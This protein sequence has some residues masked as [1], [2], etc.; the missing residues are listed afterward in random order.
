[1]EGATFNDL[2]QDIR[3]GLIDR[4]V[5][6]I[7]LNDKSDLQVRFD[8]FERL[9]TGGVELTDHEIRESV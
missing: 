8:L 4:P 1:M 6:V 3:D 2:P 5:R 9:N 7:V